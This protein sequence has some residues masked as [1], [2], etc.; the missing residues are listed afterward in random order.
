MTAYTY[1]TVDISAVAYDVLDEYATAHTY[2]TARLGAAATAWADANQDTREKGMIAALSMF[3]AMAWDGEKTDA[4]NAHCFPRSGL[5]DIEG[6]EVDE[7]TIPTPVLQAYYELAA[8]IVLDPS[9][10]DKAS[11]TGS[12]VQS[13]ASGAES[14]SFFKPTTGTRFPVAIHEKL[15]PF[16]A[17]ASAVITGEVF[18][19]DEDGN[20]PEDNHEDDDDM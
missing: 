8:A 15:R 11:A 1:P 4:D 2:M 7:D 9:L 16:L 6:E 3:D 18:G 10:Q 19:Y 14:V 20:Y 5:T 17:T 12:N 13:V